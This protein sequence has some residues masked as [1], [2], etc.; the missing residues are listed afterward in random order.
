MQ[1]RPF[2]LKFKADPYLFS[3]FFAR[4]HVV[5]Q[6]AAQARDTFVCMAE[7]EANQVFWSV[8]LPQPR[9]AEIARMRA[10][11][12]SV[13]PILRE[14]VARKASRRRTR[15]IGGRQKIAGD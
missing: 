7:P 12:I 3:D 5:L 9:R 11:A 1:L 2:L 14:V 10:H 4:R 15:D 13:G 6:L 8:Q